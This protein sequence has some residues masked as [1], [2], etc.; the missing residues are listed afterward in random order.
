M[1]LSDGKVGSV[2]EL[3]EAQRKTRDEAKAV[4]QRAADVTSDLGTVA[5]TALSSGLAGLKR[6]KLKLGVPLRPML[7]ERAATLEEAMGRM[8]GSAFVEYKYD[9]L[10]MQAHLGKTTEIFSRRLEKLTSQFPDVVKAL[11][12]AFV[13]KP[14]IVEGE[15]IAIDPKTGRMRHFQELSQRRGR[16]Y[17]LGDA[18]LGETD[19][20]D[21]IK[22]IPVRLHLFDLLWHDGED[23]TTRPLKERR[24]LLEKLLKPNEGVAL[25]ELRRLSDVKDVEE[26]F[27]AVTLTGAEGIMIKNPESEYEAGGRGYN[28]IKFKADY[29]TTLADTFDLVAIGAYWGQGRRGGWYGGLLVASYNEA[30]G[31]FESLCRLAT[32]F[33]D[34]TLAGLEKR[35]S[36]VV[37]KAKPKGVES[38]LEPDVWLQPRIVLEIQGAELT[39][40]PNHRCAWGVL[41]DDAGLSVRFPRFTGRWRDDKKAEQATTSK[42]VAKMFQ[43]RRKKQGLA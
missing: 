30:T 22:E 16:K 6:L 5:R 24:A 13:G 17:G 31:S 10:R 25:G 41:K 35:F 12:K 28:W 38:T 32:G 21:V 3:D 20:R 2:T 11:E 18:T 14:A 36:G 9:G 8:P 40:S 33:D 37:A 27:Q 29:D 1:S 39:L 34:E 42:E 19:E 23:Y 26:Y 4:V 7:A 43:V 15:V